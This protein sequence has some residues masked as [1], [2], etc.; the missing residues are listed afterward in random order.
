MIAI[1]INKAACVSCFILGLLLGAALSVVSIGNNVDTL[2]YEN[3]ELELQLESVSKELEEV[4]ST[5]SKSKGVVITKISPEIILDESKY[6]TQEAD[7]IKLVLSKEIV[8]HYQDLIGTSLKSLEPTL[9]P[10]IV[11]GRIMKV[12][13]RQF[14][15]FV[16]TMVLSETVYIEIEIE[17]NKQI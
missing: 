4:K 7:K 5:L 8:R 10:G 16:K 1:I 12:E 2:Y 14:K 6:T 11:N 3:R 13:Q 17:E 15:V 9:L